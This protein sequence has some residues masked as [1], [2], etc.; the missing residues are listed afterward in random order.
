MGSL[1]AVRSGLGL[2]ERRAWGGERVRAR[3]PAAD[4]LPHRRVLAVGAACQRGST[5]WGRRQVAVRAQAAARAQERAPLE[6]RVGAE[7]R[8]AR[9]AE[10]PADRWRGR[11]LGCPRALDGHAPFHL[12]LPC[13]A[14]GH[15][16]DRREDREGVRPIRRAG[17]VRVRGRAEHDQ[18]GLPGG[19][20]P[21]DQGARPDSRLSDGDHA[22]RHRCRRASNRPAAPGLRR[23]SLRLS[24]RPQSAQP[25]TRFARVLPSRRAVPRPACV[26]NGQTALDHAADFPG[27]LGPVVLR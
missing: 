14:R 24:A 16:Q 20:A 25:A 2:Y 5:R 1:R 19:H 21:R 12:V 6:H 9:R 27:R 13:L 18:H 7:H 22:Q 26:G 10:V 17:G 3:L 15:S 4:E 8:H 11:H 23:V